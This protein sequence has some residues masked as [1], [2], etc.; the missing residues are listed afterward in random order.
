MFTRS[1]V[2][3]DDAMYDDFHAAVQVPIGIFFLGIFE[4]GRFGM[5][6]SIYS[7]LLDLE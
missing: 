3:W 6:D 7:L 4:N 5:G 1:V 2:G